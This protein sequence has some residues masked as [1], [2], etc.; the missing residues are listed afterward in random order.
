[1]SKIFTVTLN[2]AVDRVIELGTLNIGGVSEAANQSEVAAGKGI[3]VSRALAAGSIGSTAL[4]FC[5]ARDKDLFL[6]L[7]S[8]FIR[9]V[10]FPVAGSTRSNITIV[11]SQPRRATHLKTKGYSVDANDIAAMTAAIG[12]AAGKSD[13]VA[14]AG[15]LPAGFSN[16]DLRALLGAAARC[17][18]RL[19]LD[20]AAEN[21]AAGLGFRPFA[22]KPNLEELSAIAGKTLSNVADI[23]AAAR[24]LAARGA[25]T[26][27]VTL[28]ADG[29]IIVAENGTMALQAFI[30]KT[31]R[32]SNDD[33]VGSGDAFVAGFIAAAAANEPLGD[34]IINACAYGAANQATAVPGQLDQHDV[35]RYRSLVQ[36][37]RVKGVDAR[38]KSGH[39]GA[40]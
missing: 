23:V 21:Y 39:D 9:A 1:M 26:V 13:I 12:N 5:G 16:N 19:F 28:G 37:T 22:I 29:A 32:S 8:E 17:S 36:V 11:E 34:C 7:E 30:P 40:C 18:A 25:D 27:L 33:A 10:V 31:D 14:V 38:N 35:R 2:T 4:C 24:A 6:G 20:L 3:N 15:S